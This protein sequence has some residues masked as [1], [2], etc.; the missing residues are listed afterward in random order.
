MSILERIVE[1]REKYKQLHLIVM[2]VVNK[3]REIV[4]AGDTC[5]RVN[6]RGVDPNRNFPT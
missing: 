2:P 4:L 6:E 3:N 5:I 1:N